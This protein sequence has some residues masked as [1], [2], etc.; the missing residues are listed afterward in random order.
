M[1]KF[2]KKQGFTKVWADDKSCYWW[3]KP[4]QH[5]YLNN[6]IIEVDEDMNDGMVFLRCDEI[7]FSGNDN[8][9]GD[10][11]VSLP[12]TKENVRDLIDYFD[13]PE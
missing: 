5:P 6:P 2:L 7:D 8:C 4:I 1:K 12:L 13:F 3:E 10:Y 9:V 11:I